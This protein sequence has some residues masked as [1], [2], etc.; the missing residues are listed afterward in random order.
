MNS[1]QKTLLAAIVIIGS[2][3]CTIGTMVLLFLET[4]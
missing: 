3:I 2:L 4:L 1:Y